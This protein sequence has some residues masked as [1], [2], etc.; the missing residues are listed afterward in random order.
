MLKKE[1]EKKI[2]LKKTLKITLVN[3]LNPQPWL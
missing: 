2:Q 3:M 1:T